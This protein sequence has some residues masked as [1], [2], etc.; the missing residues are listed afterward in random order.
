MSAEQPEV[1]GRVSSTPMERTATEKTRCP[2]CLAPP[3]VECE[4]QRYYAHSSRVLLA[5]REGHV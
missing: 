2:T 5:G 1:A 3:G 4:G